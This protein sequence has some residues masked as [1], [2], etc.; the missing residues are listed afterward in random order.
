MN[1]THYAQIS[2][3]RYVDTPFGRVF[4]NP[5]KLGQA[6]LVG[7]VVGMAALFGGATLGVQL[8]GGLLTS[9]LSLGA[10]VLG[11]AVSVLATLK[12]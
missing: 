10:S 1:R 9:F 8:G 4:W 11:T 5:D 7:G 2:L 12:A 3:H 6:A